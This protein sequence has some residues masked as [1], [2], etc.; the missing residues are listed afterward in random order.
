MVDPSRES[1]APPEDS[2]SSAL[3]VDVAIEA[4]SILA[5]APTGE[6]RRT[7]R[8]RIAALEESVAGWSAAE[9]GRDERRRAT[10]IAID[11]FREISHL[12]SEFFRLPCDRR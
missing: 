8:G 6:W 10:R 7:M 11:I 1:Q 2:L 4:R 12:P 5:T 9:P 3:A